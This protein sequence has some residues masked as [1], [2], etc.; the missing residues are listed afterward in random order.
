MREGSL[1]AAARV[2][3]LTQPTVGRHIDALE[4]AL[5]VKLFARS[6]HGL[7]PTS[8]ASELATHARAME[9]AAQAFARSAS[10][11]THDAQGVVR[12]TASHFVGAE[13]LPPI[14][15]DFRERQPRIAI[16]LALSDRTQDLSRRDADIA[17]RMIRPTQKALIA[18]R[19]GTVKIG[20]YAHRDYLRRHG[21]PSSVEDLAQHALIGFDRDAASIQALGTIY[22]VTREMFALRTDDSHAQLGALYAG[23]GIGGC[24]VG[25]AA[26]NPDLVPVLSGKV[27]LRLEMWLV[28]HEAQRE[29]YRVN[30]LYGHL[31]AALKAYA[32]AS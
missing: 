4:K 11:E 28:M 8:A 9:A 6:Q 31:A 3:G 32:S 13:V 18:R 15:A 10:G 27:G 17:I 29:N 24:Q 23:F 12:V 16:E 30:L 7:V 1:S 14:L 2:L 5:S 26:R 22:P 20:L 19:I 21:A 25:V